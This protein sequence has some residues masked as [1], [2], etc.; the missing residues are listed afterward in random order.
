MQIQWLGGAREVG[1]SCVYVKEDNFSCL[2][3]CGVKLSSEDMYPRLSGVNFSELDAIIVSHAHLDHSG[4]VPF[5][6]EHGYEGPVYA[7]H[8]TRMISK[9]I[10]D[11]FAKIQKHETGWAPYWRDD[12][13]TTKKHTTALD[14]KEKIEIG[15]NIFLSFLD[16]GH[17]LGSSQVLL[18]TPSQRLLYSG[19]INMSPTRVMNIADTSEWADTVI[20]EATYG[21]DNDIHPPLSESESRLID[22]IAETVKEGGRVVIPVFAIGRAQNILMTLKDACERGKIQCPIYMDGM[23]K[24]INDIYD[25]YPE[26]M[27]ESMYALFKEGNPFESPFF[28]SVDNRKRILNQSEPSVV[29]TT[30]GMMSGGPV[31]SYLNHWAKDPKT[32]FALVGYQVEG[33]LGR[34]LIDGQRHV[35]VDDKPLD[36]SARIEHITFS[37]HA[38]HDGLLTYVDSLPKPPENVFLNHGEGESLESMTRALGDKA[39][40]AE[41]LKVYT[42]K[43]SRS[44]FVPIEPS[45]TEELLHL[46][47]TTPRDEIIKTYMIRMIQ[48]ARQT[49]RIAGYVD[50]AIANEMIGALRRGVEVKIIYRHLTRPSNREAYNLLYENGA[51]IRE[52]RDMHA[53][54]VISDNR[55][56]FIS[57]ADL[58]RD[59]FYDHYEAGFLAKEDEVVRKT[60]SFY[61]KVWDESY[62]P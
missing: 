26:W 27:N 22:V 39:T 30:A 38:D 3:D 50:T 56:A 15:D 12:V 61:D 4:Y 52:N 6:F 62:V 5:L 59:S 23:L 35:T 17:I 20:L 25:D 10:Q 40:I 45:L 8:P 18:E 32:T 24:R 31:L 47:I 54:I 29:V 55:Y 28:S 44:G 13:R 14:Y 9:V 48:T 58:T 37:A 1:R 41:P 60:V 7:T 16:A 21:G 43:E 42:L 19:D 34:M 11:D 57:S 33:T 36:V 49:V 46:V 51:K 2:I 53:R